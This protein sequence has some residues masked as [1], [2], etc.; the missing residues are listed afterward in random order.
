MQCTQ[1][2]QNK[3]DSAFYKGRRQ[4]KRCRLDQKIARYD[5][6][7]QKEINDRASW[8]ARAWR[9]GVSEQ[10]LRAMWDAQERRCATCRRATN[11]PHLDHCHATGKI[12]GFL[13][14]S[15]NRVL[16]L[17]LDKPERLR[18]LAD[19]LESA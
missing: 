17:V 5:P 13:C 18:A 2:H 15:C 6:V 19:Y 4:C 11:R 10:E 14:A 7:K 12:R 8:R 9:Y 16:G 3:P 1:C